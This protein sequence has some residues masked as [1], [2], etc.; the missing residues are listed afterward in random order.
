M[1]TPQEALGKLMHY[2]AY[3]ERSH[4]EVREKLSKLKVWGAEADEIIATLIQED[5]LN[6]ERYARSF[7]RGKFRM[8]QWGRTKIRYALIRKDISAYCIKKG[9]EEIEEEEYKKTLK[10]LAATKY[11]QLKGEHY[12]KRKQ[13]TQQYLIGKGYEYDLVYEIVNNLSAGPK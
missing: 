5:F 6:E 1:A 13:K 11:E 8:K 2:C 4:K 9:L 7:A 10:K 3:Q 12:L